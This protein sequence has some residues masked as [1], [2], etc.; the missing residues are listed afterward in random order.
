MSKIKFII[1]TCEKY[2]STRAASIKN[3]W[4]KN[5]NIIFLSDKNGNNNDIISFDS[6]P[7]DYSE[8]WN[9]YY[10]LI[11]NI[12]IDEDWIFFAD[13]DTYINIENL[14]NLIFTLNK[15]DCL[16][17]GK[18]LFLSER[19]TDAENRYTGFPLNSLIGD[20]A[21]LPL[22]YASG[23]AGFLISKATFNKLKKHL[24]DSNFP[25]RSYNTDVTF[26]VWTRN[27]DIK[28]INNDLFNTINP[29]ALHHSKQ[30]IL[31]SITYHYV[32]HK[33]MEDIHSLI[34]E[35]I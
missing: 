30:Q 16:Y 35:K 34:N 17:I 31:K 8:I 10:E 20:G 12:D 13:D 11:K 33:M 27:C 22:K 19:A 21:F 15:N 32:D 5:Q 2:L 3:S 23:G 6:L 7:T 4:G 26:G 29:S 18:E 24:S 9:R 28:I 14:Q 1:L 25:A